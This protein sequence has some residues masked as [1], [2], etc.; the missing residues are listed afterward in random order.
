VQAVSD[1][2]IAEARDR[3]GV[4]LLKVEWLSYPDLATIQDLSLELVEGTNVV[5]VENG[6]EGRR[7]FQMTLKNDAGQ[8]TPTN[9]PTTQP[10]FMNN[11]I[12]IWLGLSLSGVAE[13][14]PLGTFRINRVYADAEKRTIEVDGQD[15]WKSFSWGLPQ[16]GRFAPGSSLNSIISALATV[17]GISSV[18]LDPAGDGVKLAAFPAPSLKFRRGAMR[19]ADC[20]V[21]LMRDFGWEFFFNVFGTLITRPSVAPDQQPSVFTLADTHNCFK[22]ARGGQEDSPDIFN[23]VGVSSTDPA[24]LSAFGEARDDDPTSPTYVGGSFGDRYHEEELDGVQTDGQAAAAARDILRRN[25]YLTKPIEIETNPLPHLD[26]QDVGA[27][28][29]ADLKLA[30]AS[31]FVDSMTIPLDRGTQ[32]MRLLE[33]RSIGL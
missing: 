8:W 25:L 10:L 29:I 32:T 24:F 20:F 33:A 9:S 17:A 16:S 13:Y 27:I 21:I 15:F 3:G 5:T 31:Y 26:V 11:V 14:C 28:T 2:F 4:Q 22:R 7:G 1:A 23:H 18:S 19:V 30:G 6:A 12:R